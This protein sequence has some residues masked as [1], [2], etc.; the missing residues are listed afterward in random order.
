[1]VVRSIEGASCSGGKTKIIADMNEMASGILVPIGK[2]QD[3]TLQGI[4]FSRQPDSG[5]ASA[6][7]VIP[8]SGNSAR[9]SLYVTDCSFSGFK[10]KVNPLTYCCSMSATYIMIFAPDQLSPMNLAWRRI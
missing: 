9:T 1:M 4:D 6:L 2:E 10:T 7:R 3:I 8:K 5:Y